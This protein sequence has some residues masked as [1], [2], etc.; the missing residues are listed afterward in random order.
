MMRIDR[1]VSVVSLSCW[2]SHP[3]SMEHVGSSHALKLRLRHAAT[4][5]HGP[6]GGGASLG[7]GASACRPAALDHRSRRVAVS[8]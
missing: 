5:A 8:A 7:A 3:L 1:A 4:S 6:A 2:R